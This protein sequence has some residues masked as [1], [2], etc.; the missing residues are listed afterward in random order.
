MFVSQSHNNQIYN[1]T[2]SKSASGINVNTGSSNN[3]IFGNTV[4]NSLPNAILLSGASGNTFTSNK[5]S[6]STPE[7]LKIEQDATSKN[8]IFSNA[9]ITHPTK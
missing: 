1:D 7:S 6:G 8:N 3:K 9:H 2:I 4:S 5:I